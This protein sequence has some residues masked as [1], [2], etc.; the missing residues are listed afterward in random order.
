M[1]I[2]DDLLLESYYKA[3]ELKL[4]ELFIQILKNEIERR[5]IHLVDPNTNNNSATKK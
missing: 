1:N 5:N 4:D 3:I 2:R